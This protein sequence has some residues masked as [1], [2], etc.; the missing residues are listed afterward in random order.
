MLG[1]VEWVLRR[2]EPRSNRVPIASQRDK[3]SGY[4]CREKWVGGIEFED[5]DGI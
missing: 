2:S 5:K 4:R 1:V 3:G